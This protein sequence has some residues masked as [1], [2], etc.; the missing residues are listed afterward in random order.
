MCPSRTSKNKTRKNKNRKI[1]L[2][3]GAITII[4]LIVVVFFVINNNN[5]NQITTGPPNSVLLR[6]SMG[7]ILIQLRNDTPITSNNFKNLVQNGT[8]DRTIFH[9]VMAGF[10]IQGG[11]P[12]GTGYG[13]LNIPTIPDE[14]TSDGNNTRRTVAM[15]N[16]GQPNTGSSQFFINLVDNTQGLDGKY[17]VFGD[18]ITGM[19]VVD[20]ISHVQVDTNN[21]PYSNVTITNAKYFG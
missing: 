9:R 12:S 13:D 8:Y 2:V 17:T 6:T 3:I 21:R 18:V 15:A 19:N 16:T 11:D 4:A 1:M 10:V 7:D 14:I 20:N 5:N